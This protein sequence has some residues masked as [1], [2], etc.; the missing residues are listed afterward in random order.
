MFQ[1]ARR[2]ILYCV[3]IFS[4]RDRHPPRTRAHT[5][6]GEIETTIC[7]YH[8]RED[9]YAGAHA[10]EIGGGERVFKIATPACHTL[11]NAKRCHIWAR[12][13]M[14]QMLLLMPLCAVIATGMLM[15]SLPLPAVVERQAARKNK[16]RHL[17]HKRYKSMYNTTPLPG[18]HRR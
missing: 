11:P 6:A 10:R 3:Y 15:P 4:R 14:Y 5:H 13:A 18:C 2:Y 16:Y 12:R 8:R 1:R 7:H 9:T 17:T